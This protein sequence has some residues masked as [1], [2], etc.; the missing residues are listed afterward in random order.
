MCY[1]ISSRSQG[2]PLRSKKKEEKGEILTKQTI[3][4]MLVLQYKREACK[5]ASNEI[6]ISPTALAPI[7][8][9]VHPVRKQDTSTDKVKI[10]LGERREKP[11]RIFQCQPS[12]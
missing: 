1:I 12:G 2:H 4:P 3:L 5:E 10:V 6:C 9:R 8:S 7:S 11:I